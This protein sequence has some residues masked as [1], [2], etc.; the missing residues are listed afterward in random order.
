MAEAGADEGTE[1]AV[2]RARVEEFRARGA[3]ELAEHGP[4]IDAELVLELAT[5]GSDGRHGVNL[6]VRPSPEVRTT[7]E[8]LGRA[9]R[10]LEPDQYYYPAADL[11]LTLLELGH[12]RT[13]EAADELHGR[14][15]AHAPALFHHLPA[16]HLC[17]PRLSLDAG[18]CALAFLP[19]DGGLRRLRQS[20][21]ER[22]EACGI[23][24]D[25]R[26]GAGATHVTFLRYVRPLGVELGRWLE[27]LTHLE[28][29]HPLRWTLASLW[30]T[31][32]ANWY[33]MR[34]RIREEGPYTL[35]PRAP[36]H[37][38]I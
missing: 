32:G 18:A 31:C 27:R 15:L 24:L 30:L 9:L 33:G 21:A 35:G 2:A 23:A 37:D 14:V 19:E 1:R 8:T 26:H 7:I 36:S 22:L 25:S 29:Q 34:S 12:S 28:A 16:A 13:R 20:L 4:H 11:H 38:T 5:P 6:I 10:E 17:E 3:R